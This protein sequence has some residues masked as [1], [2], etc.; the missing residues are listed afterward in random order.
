MRKRELHQQTRE[1]FRQAL[2]DPETRA[3]VAQSINQGKDIEVNIGNGKKIKV[4]ILSQH[5]DITYRK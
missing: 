5:G 4:T 2:R 3:R 1:S